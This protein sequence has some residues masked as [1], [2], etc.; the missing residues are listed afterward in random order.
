MILEIEERYNKGKNWKIAGNPVKFMGFEPLNLIPP[1]LGEHKNF[2]ANNLDTI[3]SNHPRPLFQ[4]QKKDYQCK[5]T[6]MNKDNKVSEY[7]A[8]SFTWLKSI[9]TYLICSISNAEFR[10]LENCFRYVNFQFFKVTFEKDAY[11]ERISFLNTKLSKKNI[12]DV[13][14]IDTEVEILI[15]VKI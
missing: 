3:N 8:Y 15:S 4:P 7:Y 13:S 5:V 11:E 10:P 9:E 1:D 14:I 2:Y 6:F 12:T